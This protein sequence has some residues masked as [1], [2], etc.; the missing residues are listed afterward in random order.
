[1]QTHQ[2]QNFQGFGS[3]GNAGIAVLIHRCQLCRSA[4]TNAAVAILIAY[5]PESVHSA[6]QRSSSSAVVVWF[7]GSAFAASLPSPPRR[8][9]V[10]PN[11][12]AP[13]H[14]FF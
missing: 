4:M 13:L 8:L 3:A 5:F 6:R 9:D 2:P 10:R 7:P 14:L 11:R 12:G 1:M